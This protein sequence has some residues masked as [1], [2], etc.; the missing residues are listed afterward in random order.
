MANYTDEDLDQIFNKAP[1]IHPTEPKWGKDV[2]GAWIHRD[3]H[4]KTASCGYGWEVD[5]IQPASKGGQDA[6]Y[7]Y[8]PLQWENNRNKSDNVRFRKVTSAGDKN[9]YIA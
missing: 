1:Y 6:Y 3:Q 4:G 2:A 8:R 5:H 9:V 7:N